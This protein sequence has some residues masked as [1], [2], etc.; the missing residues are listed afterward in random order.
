MNVTLR[1]LR[2]FIAVAEVQHFTRAA[3]RLDISQSSIS[4]LVRELEQNLGLRLFDRHTRM[5]R[6]THAGAEILPLAR[7]AL[8]DLDSVIGSSSELRTLGRGRVSI[9]ASSLQAALVLPEMIRRFVDAYAGVK[10][11][12]HDV[13]DDEVVEKVA[14]GEVDF[15]L[16]SAQLSRDD[17][18]SRAL[19]NDA[20]VV[21]MPADHA[22]ARR[23]EL[24]WRDLV[25]Q[26]LISPPP[27]NAVRQ[28]LDLALARAD[29]RLTRSFE[30]LLPLTILG[31][32]EAGLGIAVMTSSISR[33]ARAFGFAIREVG[34]PVIRRELSLI[35][36]V[37][38][39]LSPAAQNFRDL[40][41]DA[42]SQ[43]GEAGAVRPAG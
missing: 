43:L 35:F 13:T 6:L 40:L 16:G 25:D 32:V 5:L 41:L 20:F 12:L 22:L 27:D 38:R 11:L 19:V 31:M 28:Q 1:Q 2:A 23:R 30:V 15:G 24:T 10:V 3:E 18:S 36:H 4:T 37:D 39:S 17:I 14:K 21:V 8:A 29:I 42:R 33:L 9:A 34:G 26:P 7:K